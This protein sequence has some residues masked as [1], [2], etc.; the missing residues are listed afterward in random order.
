MDARYVVW[1]PAC[2][3][4]ADPAPVEQLPEPAWR[5]ELEAGVS[6]TRKPKRSK[7]AFAL[8]LP[9][10][11]VPAPGLLG[12]LALLAFYRPLWW[13]IPLAGVVFTLT[14]IFRP[15]LHHLPP[16]AQSVSREQA[17][18]LYDVLDRTATATGTPKLQHVMITTEPA[19]S[20]DRIGWRY[21]RVLKIGL[22][23][24]EF[25]GPQERVAAIAHTMY[26]DKRGPHDRVVRAADRILD[27]LSKYLT[28]DDRDQV[29][30]DS[31]SSGMEL[32]AVGSSEDQIQ[33][34]YVTKFVNA[35]FGPPIRSYRRLLTRL[36]LAGRL[37]R[38]YA[39]DQRVA[40]IAG[41]DAAAR[42]LERVLLADTGFRVLE[43][44]KHFGAGHDPLDLLR[45]T[46]ADLPENELRRRVL[47]SRLH[48][49]RLDADH[50]PTHRRTEAIRTIRIAPGHTTPTVLLRPAE[51]TRIDRDLTPTAQATIKSLRYHS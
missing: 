24:W 9:V 17:P 40:S 32:V 50:P 30:Y 43:R 48:N 7:R 13:S 26:D 5:T 4:N 28:A 37:Q 6:A 15:R 14:A 47:V 41:A 21:R 42:A 45:R 46:A 39:A 22:P 27:D 23:A 11:M 10:L 44:S 3:W 12:G 29:R 25:L 51:N 33:H 1:C 34:Y 38:V 31:Y 18:L 19:V 49:A 35:V 20:I 16:D 8:A 36:D 2:G